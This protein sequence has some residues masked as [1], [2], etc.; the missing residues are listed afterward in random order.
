MVTMYPIKTI[1]YIKHQVNEK[2]I[3]IILEQVVGIA[4]LLPYENTARMA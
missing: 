1:R 2:L 3:T 4:L